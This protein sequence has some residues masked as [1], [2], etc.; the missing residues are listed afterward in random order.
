MILPYNLNYASQFANYK[1]GNTSDATVPELAEGGVSEVGGNHK[2]NADKFYYD[3]LEWLDSRNDKLWNSD[4]ESS[5]VK[6]ESDPCPEGWRVPTDAELNEL[7]KNRSSWTTNTAEQPG[8]WFSGTSSYTED[9]PQVFFPAAGNRDGYDASLRGLCGCYWSSLPN[10]YSVYYDDKSCYPAY[11]LFF[12]SDS[13][14]RS[15]SPRAYGYSV[16]CVQE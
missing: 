12:S 16:R 10:D 3:R 7:R 5:P 13:A 14:S 2:S 9:V 11:Y 8:Y 1:R 15:R 6:T 4:S